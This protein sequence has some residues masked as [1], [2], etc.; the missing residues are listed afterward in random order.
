MFERGDGSLEQTER[1]VE[2]FAKVQNAAK[3]KMSLEKFKEQM[4][5]Q[6][7]QG[8]A[9]E[10][11]VFRLEQFR[12]LGEQNESKVKRISGI[13]VSAGYDIVSFENGDS[14]NYDRFVEVKFFCGQSHFYWSK[15]EIDTA[16]LL[17]G[18]YH[19]YLINAEK[20][21][22]PN[23]VPMIICNPAKVILDSGDWLMQPTSYLVL[24]T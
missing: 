5:Q 9:A 3:R 7:A 21:D 6:A 23:Y 24:P 16:S 20:V 10:E 11:F 19:I 18:Q 13:D 8:K 22:N 12:L 4:E 1:Y 15:N 2:V 17:G 14:V